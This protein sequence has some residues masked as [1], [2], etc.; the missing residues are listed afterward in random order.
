[1]SLLG[2]RLGVPK[3]PITRS[4]NFYIQVSFLVVEFLLSQWQVGENHLDIA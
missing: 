4:E 3:E 2:E 1:M